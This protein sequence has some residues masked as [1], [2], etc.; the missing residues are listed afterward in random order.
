M[1]ILVNSNKF[2]KDTEDGLCIEIWRNS[3]N[4]GLERWIKLKDDE[5]TYWF[6]F[7]TCCW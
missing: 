4:R 5:V 7:F 1:D 3:D 6:V 2:E